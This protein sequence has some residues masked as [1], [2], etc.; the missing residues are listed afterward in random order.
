MAGIMRKVYSSV[1]NR[2]HSRARKHCQHSTVGGSRRCKNGKVIVDYK[3]DIDYEPNGPDPSNKPVTQKEEKDDSDKE[4]SKWSSI[5]K[6]LREDDALSIRK[7][8]QAC[9]CNTRT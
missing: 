2:W 1:T 5:A 7:L 3:P 6:G 4:Y 8:D 9:T